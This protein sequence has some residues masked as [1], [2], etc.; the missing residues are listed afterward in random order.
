MK[1]NNPCIGVCKFDAATDMCK[2]C[3]R[4]R[5]ER[6]TW[7]SVS[8]ESRV[9]IIAL[10]PE[11]EQ[12][13]IAAGTALAPSKPTKSKPSKKGAEKASKHAKKDAKK[14]DRKSKKAERKAKK[15]GKQK[16]AK[17]KD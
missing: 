11:R 15:K 1:V 12:M 8:E 2:A 9:A 7:K 6:K 3:F 10:R 17:A 16:S 5:D 13:L 14:K 4:T